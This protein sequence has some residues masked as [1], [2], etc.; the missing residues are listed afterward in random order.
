MKRKQR[1]LTIFWSA[2]LVLSLICSTTA[3]AGQLQERMKA[4]LPEI[5]ALKSKGV[6]GENHK[7]YLEFVGQRRDGAAVVKAENADRQ[8]LYTAI[9]QKTGASPEQ[10]GSRAALKWKAN[11]AA[12]EYFKNPDGRWIQ[13]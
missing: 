13:K 1:I 11:L 3:F 5:V 8:A 9:A 12:G 7:G 2:A 10:V 4:R 6:I